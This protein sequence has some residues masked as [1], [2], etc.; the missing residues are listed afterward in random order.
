MAPRA[1]SRS[2][3]PNEWPL[4]VTKAECVLRSGSLGWSDRWLLQSFLIGRLPIEAS[5]SQDLGPY[6]PPGG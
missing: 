6:E 3:L 2:S 5:L 4:S 1:D